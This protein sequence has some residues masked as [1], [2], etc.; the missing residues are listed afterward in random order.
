VFFIEASFA[1]GEEERAQDRAHLTTTAAGEIA[2]AADARRVEPF[3]FSPRYE[4]EEERLV[5]EVQRAF[6]GGAG[7]G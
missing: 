7:A 1:A 2:R 3:H 4:G 6:A 5:A